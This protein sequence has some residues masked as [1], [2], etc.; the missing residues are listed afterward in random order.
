MPTTFL[1]LMLFG[2]LVAVIAFTGPAPAQVKKKPDPE[3]PAFPNFPGFPGAP[4]QPVVP[5]PKGKKKGADPG[6]FGGMNP[7]FPNIQLPPGFGGGFGM[8]NIGFL[9]GFNQPQ[10][11]KLAA[12][13]EAAEQALRAAR[14][15]LHLEPPKFAL[16]AGKRVQIAPGGHVDHVGFPADVK[17][18]DLA[19]LIPHCARLPQLKSIDLGHTTNVTAAGL[20]HLAKLRNVESLFLDHTA[21][22]GD[23]LKEAGNVKGLKWLDISGTPVSDE[24]IKL[25]GGINALQSLIIR[26][27][28]NLTAEGMANVVAIPQ[29]R[30]L[31]VTVEKDPE[32]MT[33]A[34]AAGRNLN[35]LK[36]GGIRDTECV[37]FARMDALDTL[38][39][40]NDDFRNFD[41]RRNKAVNASNTITYAGLNRLAPM[42]S[43]RVLDAGHNSGITGDGLDDFTK[44]PRL[45]ELILQGTG[46]SNTGIIKLTR[47]P[48]LRVLDLRA[49]SVTDAGMA[50]LADLPAVERLLLADLPLTDD[51]LKEL[52]RLRSL[53]VLDLS[54]TRVTAAVR[55]LKYFTQIE[56]L[57]L[58]ST[59]VSTASFHHLG[60]LKSLRILNLHDNCPEV[61][62]DTIKKL[63]EELPNCAVLASYCGATVNAQFMGMWIGW[64]GAVYY[65]FK[66]PEMKLPTFT[67]PTKMPSLIGY[68]PPPAD[69]GVT[70]KI[71]PPPPPPPPNFR[72]AVGGGTGRP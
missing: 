31:N 41:A 47:L 69:A 71:P 55:D 64:P 20:K 60:Q 42:R 8:P 59:S 22:D 7:A 3:N 56:Q 67:A 66:M 63:Q 24:G 12:G 54:G 38:D 18:A 4:G 27:M 70:V 49:T 61:T 39:L 25:A 65:P 48:T 6:D 17:D 9:P 36:I 1:R 34:I 19:R 46:F 57:H 44:L 16:R 21:A 35:H 10:R 50:D 15:G 40:S 13:E 43:L 51:G 11:P 58:V 2:G 33:K 30:F 45:E 32:G 29:L 26:G 52:T 62:V 72:P 23:W 14:C 68:K 28:P 53:I 5:Q 37:H